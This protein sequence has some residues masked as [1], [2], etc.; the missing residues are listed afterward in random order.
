MGLQDVLASIPGR[1]AYLAQQQ[2]DQQQTGGQLAQLLGISNFMESRQQHAIQ[3]EMRQAQ[4]AELQRKN[5]MAEQQAQQFET[6]ISSLPPQMQALA[7]MN[8]QKYAE[9]MLKQDDLKIVPAGGVAIRG[10]KEVYTNPRA[11]RDTRHPYE[12]LLDASGI[13][14]PAERAQRLKQFMDKQSTHPAPVNVYSTN[15]VPGVDA[16]NNP[17]F[18]QPS[19]RPGVPPQIV[20]NVFPAPKGAGD[21]D[22]RQAQTNVGEYE[23]ADQIIQQMIRSV[24]SGSPVVG[25]P[26]KVAQGVEAIRG[27]VDQS[28]PSPAIDLQ[29]QKEMLIDKMK[30]L[31]TRR[32][33]NMSNKDVERL[34]QVLGLDKMM[35]N[36]GAAVRAMTN[37]QN[38]LRRRRMN[39]DVRPRDSGG[40]RP[41]QVVDG[42]RF[43]GGDPAQ[44]SNWEKQ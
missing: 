6:A 4:M 32:D 41:G 12:K 1:G 39:L 37:V 34:E 44:Q 7:R 18:A 5:A 35:T 30:N 14:D 25:I 10:D 22:Q 38:D 16:N 2:F 17:V 23:A 28:A 26:G 29:T 13:T 36:P 11:E 3:N 31:A 15:M 33:S 40:P 19:G 43:K 9:L 24:Q 20:P 21:K 27:T 8:P 42:Y